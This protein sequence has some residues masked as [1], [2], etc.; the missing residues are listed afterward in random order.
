MILHDNILSN[1]GNQIIAV[2]WWT[3]EQTLKNYK[4]ENEIEE[5]LEDHRSHETKTLCN[6]QTIAL[7]F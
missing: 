7:Q 2:E 4:R 3:N 5:D 6:S 1:I